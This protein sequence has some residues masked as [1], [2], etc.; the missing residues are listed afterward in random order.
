MQQMHFGG[1]L[2]LELDH[3]EG[4]AVERLR[5]WPMNKLAMQVQPVCYTSMYIQAYVCTYALIC[6]NRE[7]GRCERE[8]V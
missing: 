6:L 3:C 4:E 5:K 1:L 7:R 2:S 8:P